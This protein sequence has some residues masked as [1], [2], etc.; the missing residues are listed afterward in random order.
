MRGVTRVTVLT[1]LISLTSVSGVVSQTIRGHVVDT[2]DRP[3]SGVAI[4]ITRD[5]WIQRATS[6]S[7]GTFTVQLPA[8]GTYRLRAELLGHLTVD[9]AFVAVAWRE[10]VEITVRMGWAAIRLDPIV[11]R[12]RRLDPRH[13][14]TLEG[15]YTRRRTAPPVGNARV[16]TRTDPEMRSAIT[17]FDVLRWFSPRG[18]CL[19]VFI[20]GLHRSRITPDELPVVD[21]LIGLEYYKRSTDAPLELKPAHVTCPIVALWTH[22]AR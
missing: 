7:A 13:M 1:L 15:F 10:L 9:S 14:A 6:D 18:A 20:N 4:S 8:V 11:V 12:S 22:A 2:N 5:R 3:L 17:V 21:D 16:V 19:H